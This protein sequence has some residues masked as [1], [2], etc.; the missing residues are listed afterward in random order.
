MTHH[1][2]DDDSRS[3][4]KSITKVKR[5]RTR[6]LTSKTN[7]TSKVP[8]GPRPIPIPK[9]DAERKEIADFERF[10]ESTKDFRA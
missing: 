2:G 9:T 1:L 5:A 10:Y 7:L 4:S 8:E 3:S 6:R